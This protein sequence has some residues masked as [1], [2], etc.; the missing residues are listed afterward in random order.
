MSNILRQSGIYCIENLISG[1]KYI[2]QSVNIQ[3]RWNHHICELNKGIHYNDHLQKAWDLYGKSNFKFYVLEYCSPEN[4]DQR[5]IFYIEQYNTLDEQFGYNLKPGGQLIG[6]CQ[7]KVRHK[8]SSGLLKYYLDP[9]RK[10]HQRKNALKQWA[11]P[12]IK[13]K[14]MGKNNGM[15]GKHHSSESKEKMSK[16]KLGKSVNMKYTSAVIC[17][18]L[19]KIYDNAVAAGKEMH[20]D[21]SSILKVCRNERKTCGGY[22]W[23]FINI[24]KE[25]I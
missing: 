5:E 8:I 20:L 18:E 23:K 10:E 4:L 16:A 9:T 13:Q 25:I 15:F 11:D 12:K 3:N 17:V 19:N 7:E 22:S 2:G 14:I 6:S 21:Q 1:K 24:N